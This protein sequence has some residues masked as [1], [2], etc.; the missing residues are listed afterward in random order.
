MTSAS[1]DARNSCIATPISSLIARA[2]DFRLR[3]KYAWLVGALV[4]GAPACSWR[5]GTI[6]GIGS[7]RFGATEPAVF[8]ATRPASQTVGQVASPTTWPVSVERA[9]TRRGGG[10]GGRAGEYLINGVTI[11]RLVY[12]LSPLVRASREAM[13][14]ARHALVEFRANLSRFEPFATTTG[15]VSQF[16]HRRDSRTTQGEI[17]AGIEK[18]TFEG[19]IFRIEGGA[20][21]SHAEF[22]EVNQNQD[23]VESGSGG[24]V[25]GRIEVPFVGSRKRQDRVIQEAF[26]EWSAR[27]AEFQYLS[28]YR[29][30]VIQALNYYEDALY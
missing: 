28:E 2:C 21:A 12:E 13:I 25:R 22:G 23:E 6:S 15:D 5:P 10:R 9:T 14:A 1:L 17:V 7:G 27:Q 18:G 19:A 26:Q 30:R 24:L 20:S 16:P 3:W 8:V 4:L 29:R 11:V